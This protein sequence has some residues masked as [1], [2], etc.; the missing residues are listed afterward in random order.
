MIPKILHQIWMQGKH[1]IPPH[2]LKIQDSWIQ[3]HPQWH[4]F[5]LANK[6]VSF[7]ILK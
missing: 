2:L 6:S 1:K 4:R 5:K 3:T 7:K